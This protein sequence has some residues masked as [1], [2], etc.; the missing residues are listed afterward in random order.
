MARYVPVWG[1]GGEVRGEPAF[2]VGAKCGGERDGRGG[3]GSVH[4]VIEECGVFGSFESVADL[5]A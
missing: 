1:S 3:W 2:G 5:F 4:V